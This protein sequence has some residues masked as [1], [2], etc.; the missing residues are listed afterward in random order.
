MGHRGATI[1][2]LTA[3]VFGAALAGTGAPDAAA[4]GT[5]ARPKAKSPSL[6]LRPIPTLTVKLGDTLTTSIWMRARGA[7]PENFRFS[8]SP[9]PLPAGASLDAVTGVFTFAPSA[10]QVGKRKITFSVTDGTSTASRATTLVVKGAPPNGKTSLTGR[11]LDGNTFATTGNSVAV[12]GAKVS[13]VGT[14]VSAKTNSRGAF[15]LKNAPSGAQVLDIDCTNARKAKDG[16]SYAGFRET[17]SLIDK[18]TNVRRRPFY[19]PRIAA[20]SLTTIDPAAT[21]TVKNAAIGVSFVVPPHTAK[22]ADGSDF[23]GQMSVSEVVDAVAPVAKPPGLHPGLL[24]TIQPIGVKFATPASITFPNVDHLAP[25]SESDV[26][27]LDAASGKFVVVGRSV[28]SSDGASITTTSGGVRAADWHFPAPPPPPPPGPGPDDGPD[29]D[30]PSPSPPPH[31][32]DDWNFPPPPHL[33][34]DWNYGPPPDA[35]PPDDDCS[36]DSGSRAIPFD[37]TELVHFDLPACVSLGR[38]RTLRF[39]WSSARAAPTPVVPVKTI[40]P[41]RSAVPP[42]ISY[43]LSVGGATQGPETFV[44]TD[45]FSESKDEPFV[46]AAAFDASTFATGWYPVEMRLTSVYEHTQVSS[47]VRKHVNVVNESA[48]PFGRGWGLDGLQR[49]AFTADGGALVV[50][51]SGASS[52]FQPGAGSRRDFLVADIQTNRILRFNGDTGDFVGVVVDSGAGGLLNPHAPIIGPDGNVYVVSDDADGGA[53]VRRYD[54]ATG[55]YLGDFVPTSAAIGPTAMIAFGPDGNLYTSGAN[56]GNVVRRFSGVDGSFLGVAAQ[57]HGISR[58]CGIAFGPTDHLLY[59]LDADAFISTYYDRILRF[60]G[61]TGAFVDEFVHPGNLDDTCGFNF[62]PDGDI[63]VADL[64]TSDVRRFSGADGH[65]V[66][67]F[68]SGGPLATTTPYFTFAGQDPNAIYVVNNDIYRYDLSTGVGT[69]VVPGAVGYSS[70]YPPPAVGP[71]GAFRSPPGDTSHLDKQSDGTY[72]RGYL[73]G[74][75]VSFD[76]NGRETT[77]V[78]RNG[79]TTVISYD[80]QGRVSR[81]V[82][83]GA[84]TFDL[85]YGTDGKLST[86]V[87]GTGRATTFHHDAAGNLSA[88]DVPGNGTRQFGYDARNL[89]T[90]ETDPLA[91]VTT[92]EYDAFGRWK[93]STLP[94]NVVRSATHSQL[95]GL[96]DPA[97]G[98]GTAANPAPI[99]RPSDAVSTFTDGASVTTTTTTGALG[100]TA[101]LVDAAGLESDFDRSSSGDIL[102]IA[103]P[104][105]TVIRGVHDSSRNLV[106]L[107]DELVGGKSTFTYVAGTDRVAT[108][109]DV[110]SATTAWAHDAAGDVTSMTSPTGLVAS[111]AY[112]SRGLLASRVDL[113]GTTTQFT[114][115]ATGNLVSVAA[116]AGAS[117]RTSSFVR[118]QEGYVASATDALGR[119]V[120]FT[121]DA[122]GRLVATTLPGARVVATTYD[123][124]GRV[125]SITAPGGAAHAFAW[126]PF[127]Q[128]T[129]YVAPSVGAEPNATTYVYDAGQKLTRIQRP[130]GSSVALSYDAAGRLSTLDIARGQIARTYSATTGLVVAVAAPGNVNLAVG[131]TGELVTSESTTGAVASSVQTQFDAARRRGA[132]Q[133]AGAAPITYVYDLEGRL[134]QAGPVGSTYSAQTGLLAGTT[135]GTISDAWTFDAFGDAASYVV[136]RG[137]TTLYSVSDTRDKVGRVTARTETIGGATTNYAYSYDAAGRLANVTIGGVQSAAYAYDADGNRTS[138]TAAAAE[139]GTYDA[140]DRVTAYGAATFANAL[141][142]ERTSRT[143]AGQTTSYV[144]DEL[145]NLASVALPG[146]TTIDYVI[147]GLNRRVARRVGSATDRAFVWDGRRIAAELDGAGA[148][149]SVFVYSTRGDVPDAMIRGG[150]TYRIVCDPAGSPRLVVDAATGAVAQRVDY[151]EFGRVLSDT[152]P[153]FQPFGFAGGLYDSA[154]GL[155]RF[156]A[157]DY[158]AE[159]G[160]WTAKDPVLLAGGDANLYSYCGD[161]PLNRRDPTGTFSCRIRFKLKLNWGD[162][163]FG[164]GIGF[165]FDLGP[166]HGGFG[167]GGGFDAWSGPVDGPFPNTPQ[168]GSGSGWSFGFGGGAG[169]GIGDAGVGVGGGLGAGSNSTSVGIAGGF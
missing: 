7:S 56:V 5:S 91:N 6:S 48:S 126:S 18:A 87:D 118:T 135:T 66:G 74:R 69:L 51:G 100:K 79:N 95:A 21:T 160:R 153:G 92:R 89:M 167:F 81:V 75:V 163:G 132:T 38:P 161:D 136:T 86:V 54:E 142:G 139:N 151:D 19:M 42:K 49:I 17:I 52:R 115:D 113:L 28:V 150:V 119:S 137:S 29:Y 148:L 108:A 8:A 155:V 105:G 45:G 117:Q 73:D 65:F 146:G 55:T 23:T 143:A 94:G 144:Y 70:A 32:P 71:S 39:V 47:F 64:R 16:S 37:G 78:D 112:D 93:R 3:V 127:G 165:G 124:D 57:G 107:S 138:R 99:R 15:T 9:L 63:Y 88:I 33:P 61:P 31:V 53:A 13:L 90:S 41:V 96:V 122:N 58:P 130:G 27:S 133:V 123:L 168:E 68:A 111:G 154:T 26:W 30:D 46:V 72:R 149:R 84:M 169:F 103:T 62:G 85:T 24:V 114:Y 109:T 11:L 157:R 43:Q 152:N 44:S 134:T 40:I 159:T 131:Y 12:V 82:D 34:D 125:M 97:S 1:R 98:L 104:D 60:D 140:Q 2:I 36:A 164:I 116:G 20:A 67:V 76:A 120:S 101:R 83:P 110:F 14:N 35:D 128:M 50:D 162:G 147:D 121:Y 106:S 80:A 59:V 25:G 102:R 22:N 4:D 10:D 141:S 77:D 158:D 145:G 129:S 166:I 156:G